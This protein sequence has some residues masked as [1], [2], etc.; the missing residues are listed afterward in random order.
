[1]VGRD[2]P[3][4][5]GG[6]DRATRLGCIVVNCSVGLYEAAYASGMETEAARGP[7]S[8]L[9]R[10]FSPPSRKSHGPRFNAPKGTAASTT[11]VS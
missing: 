11:A 3:A 8:P 9:P 1:M 7:L 2:C 5:R 10:Y 6:F 4:L